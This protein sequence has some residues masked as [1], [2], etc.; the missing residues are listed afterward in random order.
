MLMLPSPKGKRRLR[1]C[2][3][4][5]IVMGDE[6][7]RQLV[8]SFRNG[9]DVSRVRQGSSFNEL[10]PCSGLLRPSDW[11]LPKTRPQGSN[12][13]NEQ[14][15]QFDGFSEPKWLLLT[16]PTTHGKTHRECSGGGGGG[17]WII[18]RFQMDVVYVSV[19][20]ITRVC[21]MFLEC[22]GPHGCHKIER[23]GD[24]LECKLSVE[25]AS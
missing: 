13:K 21:R 23:R 11:A 5:G 15:V 10:E 7:H 4:M 17:R 16:R 19:E 6:R 8:H 20:A 24:G 2:D 14:H 18:L 9:K 1:E 12:N 22:A 3:R 25:R